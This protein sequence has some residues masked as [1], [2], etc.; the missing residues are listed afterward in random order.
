MLGKNEKEERSLP[1]WES[2][3]GEKFDRER[4]FYRCLHHVAIPVTTPATPEAK[5]V[6]ERRELNEGVG[7]SNNP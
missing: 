5:G 2:K 1:E 3:M 6:E 7:L 4:F